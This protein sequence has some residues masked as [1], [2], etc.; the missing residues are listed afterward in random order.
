VADC[1]QYGF[2]ISVAI[3]DGNIFSQL[4]DSYFLKP[5][6]LTLC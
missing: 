1:F 6:F 2:E 3:K 5:D 4:S